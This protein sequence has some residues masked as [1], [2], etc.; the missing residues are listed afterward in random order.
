MASLENPTLHHIA[1]RKIV[2]RPSC[3]FQYNSF[4]ILSSMEHS[5]SAQSQTTTLEAC[6]FKEIFESTIAHALQCRILMHFHI[7]FFGCKIISQLKNILRAD[8]ISPATFGVERFGSGSQR[9]KNQNMIPIR[10]GPTT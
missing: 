2:W 8:E 9:I 10:L 4:D 1:I 3:V 5:D 7:K 6:I